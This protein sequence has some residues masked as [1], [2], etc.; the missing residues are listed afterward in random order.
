M[1]FIKKLRK[2]TRDPG[3]KAGGA[4]PENT[5]STEK[6][7]S[8]PQESVK[9]SAIFRKLKEIGYKTGE[10]KIAFGKRKKSSAKAREKKQEK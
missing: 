7:P 6:D 9:R 10:I 5:L 8:P 2:T 1:D 4:Q 3:E